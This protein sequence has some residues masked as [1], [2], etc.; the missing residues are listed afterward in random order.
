MLP[1]LCK[2]A[3]GGLALGKTALVFWDGCKWIKNGLLCAWVGKTESHFLLTCLGKTSAVLGRGNHLCGGER[4][5]GWA[6]IRQR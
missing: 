2:I 5:I 6:Q 4:W 1:S 3:W